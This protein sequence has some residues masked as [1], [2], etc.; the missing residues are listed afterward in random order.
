MGPGSCEDRQP[1]SAWYRC[2]IRAASQ[3]AQWNPVWH[4][5]STSSAFCRSS[6]TWWTAWCETRLDRRHDTSTEKTAWSKTCGR[7]WLIKTYIRLASVDVQKSTR[8]KKLRSWKK[9]QVLSNNHIQAPIP[10][11]TKSRQPN[12]SQ[13][14]LDNAYV[15]YWCLV[16]V[17][18]NSN[19]ITVATG[20]AT[21]IWALAHLPIVVI[22]P[23]FITIWSLPKTYSLSSAL[24]CSIQQSR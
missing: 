24:S 2:P 13:P 4:S 1:D 22:H 21:T 6:A 14:S 19:D 17:R 3:A 15:V 5:C 11:D 12:T 10:W 23:K 16:N 20:Y 7:H 9:G 8:Y 18:G